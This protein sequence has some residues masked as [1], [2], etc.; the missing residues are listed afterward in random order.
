MISNKDQ[1]N[2]NCL[3]GIILFNS[4]AQEEDY[5]KYETNL[6]ALEIASQNE[7]RLD[8][9]NHCF[10]KISNDGTDVTVD[11]GLKIVNGNLDIDSNANYVVSNKYYSHDAMILKS[12]ENV[13]TSHLEITGSEIRG[14]DPAVGGGDVDG[15][16]RFPNGVNIIND[17]TIQDSQFG[18]PE[19]QATNQF[20]IRSNPVGVTANNY[21]EFTGDTLRASNAATNTIPLNITSDLNV[22]AG[23]GVLTGGANHTV[24]SHGGNQDHTTKNQE[25]LNNT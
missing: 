16:V 17:L 22:N 25:H 2:D 8:V 5:I 18:I 24:T 12:N 7:I 23:H 3:N 15:L 20:H 21:I 19:I 6:N 14:K 1:L 13:L 4:N 9:D 11:G 10:L